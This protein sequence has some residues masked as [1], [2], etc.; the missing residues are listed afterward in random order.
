VLM[1]PPD[2][3]GQSGLTILVL[4]DSSSMTSLLNPPLDEQTDVGLHYP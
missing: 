2:T 3:E 1:M 4:L